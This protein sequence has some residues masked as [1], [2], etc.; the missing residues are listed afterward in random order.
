M[1]TRSDELGSVRLPATR[2]EWL[3]HRKIKATRTFND[4]VESAHLA[5]LDDLADNGYKELFDAI[6]NKDAKEGSLKHDSISA[7]T[8]L[9]EYAEEK[10]ILEIK[11]ATL[12]AIE[13]AQNVNLRRYGFS[14][15]ERR[16][17][18]P[19]NQPAE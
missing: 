18:T 10:R 13:K 6:Y 5:A 12:K 17:G 19:A 1:P 4:I 11:G 7:A 3:P 14:R 15:K 9:R 8:K 2:A 16:A